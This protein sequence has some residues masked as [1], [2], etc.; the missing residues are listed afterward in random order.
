VIDRPDS[1][2]DSK[3]DIRRGIAVCIAAFCSVALTGCPK[4]SADNSG[5]P[6]PTGPGQNGTKLQIAVIPKGT[7]N[8]FWQSIKAG[9]DA[10]CSDPANNCSVVWDGPNPENDLT[11]Q[12]NIVNTMVNKK[13]AAIVLA[14]CDKNAL[15]APVKA[16]MTAGIPVVTIDS[17]IAS[18]DPVAYIATNNVKGGEAAADA[19]AKLME[20]KGKAGYL[21]FGKG[22]VSSDDRQRGFEEG[23]KK[24]PGITLL[25][26]LEASDAGKAFNNVNNLLT[27]HPDIG[28][29]FAANEPNG[30]SA[31]Q[32]LDQKK[33]AGKVKLV[34]FDASDKEV[35][36]LQSGT[37]QA[38]IVQDPYQMGYKGVTTA[39]LAV[40]KQPIAEKT[41]DSGLKVVTKENLNTP[42]IQKL[43]H[44][45]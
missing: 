11:A 15:I 17:G 26:F 13:V 30:I 24:H 43:L 33:L 39:L 34:A 2:G 10:A 5:A 14:A 45:K 36:A 25:P 19:L 42:E 28:G 40:K 21:I 35:E 41:V 31:A 3:L 16:A 22:Q 7:E 8:Q 9:A 6:A 29:I 12:V 37:I 23:M 20:E 38:L 27:A 4:P 1:Q 44:P 18:D 32:V